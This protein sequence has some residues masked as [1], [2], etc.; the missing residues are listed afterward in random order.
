MPDGKVVVLTK[1]DMVV[2]CRVRMKPRSVPDAEQYSRFGTKMKRNKM[3]LDCEWCR[4][5]MLC[6][7]RECTIYRCPRCGRGRDI[8]K[9]IDLA[10]SRKEL[11]K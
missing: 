4:S 1:G 8:E 7:N 5:A 9:H 3:G 6:V 2:T 11:I 10:S